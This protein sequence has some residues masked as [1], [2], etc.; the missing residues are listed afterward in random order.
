MP[1]IKADHL[2]L[3]WMLAVFDNRLI[4]IVAM[5]I[6]IGISAPNVVA[7]VG[8]QLSDWEQQS[9]SRG[10]F[11]ALRLDYEHLK[12]QL[13]NVPASSN[14]NEIVSVQNNVKPFSESSCSSFLDS[15][16]LIPG[17]Q[18][19]RASDWMSLG[20]LQRK[21]MRVGR[22]GDID[23]Y[24]G[25]D[26]VGRVQYLRQS[27]VV[28]S[29]G[30][31]S[32]VSGPLEPGFQTPFGQFSFL[33]D[34]G[35]GAIEAYADIFIASRPHEDELQADEG[36]ILFR[37]MPG[38]LGGI[39]LVRAFFDQANIKFGA[40]EIDFGDAHYRRSNNADTQRNPL[41]GNY[42][43]DPRGTDLGFE[44]FGKPG[45]RP[46]NWLLGMGVG[47]AGDFQ[48]AR[49]LQVH[50][51][52]FGDSVG[53]IRPAISFYWADNSGNPTGFPNS[54]SKSDLFQS[55]R[56]GG[57]YEDVLSGGNAPG[58]ISP[59][60]GQDVSAVQFDLTLPGNCW[61]LYGYVGLVQ[62]N[63]ING[64]GPGTPTESWVYYAGE[65]IYHI[66]P[67]FY[68]A[69]RYSGASASHLVSAFDPT[70]DVRS[71]GHVHRFQVGGGY[72]I[73]ETILAKFEY[74]HQLYNGFTPDGSQVSGVDVWDDPSF[75][76][77][78]TEVSFSF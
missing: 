54:G 6:A 48:A 45:Q 17:W 38:P 46:V 14:P 43:I 71:D 70:L 41:I 18:R 5:L 63:D 29:I 52:L 3:N 8:N 74:V 7:Q 36:Y 56:A 30:A 11:E 20:R 59:G 15:G 68:V 77:L 65:G 66:T 4:T 47:N 53:R 69:G 10:E 75:N 13:H 33:A 9:V 51:K 26:T 19:V 1:I 2:P 37:Q 55:N 16:C 39:G 44:I 32:V 61:E 23:L 28:D 58:Q 72:W 21:S 60:N 49:G 24:L 64:S 12:A 27:N 62:D 57:P 50:G 78:L 40:F 25:L 76:G 35:E 22:A 42:V 34:I 73:H 31:D 67:R